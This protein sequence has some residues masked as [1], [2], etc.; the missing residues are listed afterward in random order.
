[1]EEKEYDFEA[2][3]WQWTKTNIPCHPNEVTFVT[4]QRNRPMKTFMLIWSVSLALLARLKLGWIRN[5]QVCV[6]NN[7]V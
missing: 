7:I 3:D 4:A 1:V 6:L 2:Y 5:I